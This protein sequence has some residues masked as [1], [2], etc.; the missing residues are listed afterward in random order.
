MVF[1]SR[2]HTVYALSDVSFDIVEGEFLT[3]LGPS[4]CGKSTLLRILAGLL[5]CTRGEV[6]YKG[7]PL[8]G[9]QR[10]IAVIFQDP[11]LLPWRT[12]MKNVML[13]VEVLGLDKRT[14]TQQASKL[15]EL[16]GLAGFE[17]SYPWELSGG[18]K[19][20]VSIA[21]AL[22]TDPSIMLMDEPFGGLDMVTR[23]Q[24][25]MELLR[26]CEETGK[27]VFF[28]THS[29]TEA[30]FLGERTIVMTGRPG[31]VKATFSIS[32]QSRDRDVLYTQQFGQ[33]VKKVEAEMQKV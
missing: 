8:I 33:Y 20:R 2:D 4:G 30:I 25:N 13:P 31:T 24:M 17:K 26:I 1:P 3:V 16:V 11:V 29:V 21:R 22:L 28:I 9:P 32:L 6:L 7:I 5:R 15:L 12:I 14:Y 27:T 23:E 18:M 19:Q 10:D